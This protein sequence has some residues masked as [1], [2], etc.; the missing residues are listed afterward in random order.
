MSSYVGLTR[1]GC[2]VAGSARQKTPLNSVG[3]NRSWK[4]LPRSLLHRNFLLKKLFVENVDDLHNIWSDDGTA[5][6]T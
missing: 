2:F 3:V 5:I 6:Q 1:F 4:N